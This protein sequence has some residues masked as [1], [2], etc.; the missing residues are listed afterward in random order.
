MKLLNVLLCFSLL[1]DLQSRNQLL[2][3][4]GIAVSLWS[5]TAIQNQQTRIDWFDLNTASFQA[6]QHQKE[7]Q[8]R[9]CLEY[10]F[11]H[12]LSSACPHDTH[13]W[14][15]LKLEEGERAEQDAQ[16]SSCRGTAGSWNRFPPTAEDRP[17]PSRSEI[18]REF[19]R[20]RLQNG[21]RNRPRTRKTGGACR[22]MTCSLVI[23]MNVG[24][25]FREILSYGLI[26]RNFS[27]L[28]FS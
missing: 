15:T 19:A 2:S 12:E 9:A 1:Y 28:L 7:N 5:E 10:Q 16:R 3:G 20:A 27:V 11:A 17:H 23:G 18:W 26:Y 21:P 25:I 8:T 22:A 24:N 6:V 14:G 13:L 4:L